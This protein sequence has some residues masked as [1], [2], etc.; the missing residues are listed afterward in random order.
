MKRLLIASI[1]VTA[2]A[3]APRGARAPTPL[4][5]VDTA[6]YVVP[7]NTR[8]QWA[9]V[10]PRA[11]RAAG[12]TSGAP[13]YTVGHVM[14]SVGGTRTTSIGC[15][16]D[17]F[18]V[19]LRLG[20]VMP[21]LA[22]NASPSAEDRAAWDAFV[23]RLWERAHRREAIGARL[24]DSLRKELKTAR[25]MECPQLLTVT[26]EKLDEFP[27]RYSAAV[28]AAEAEQGSVAGPEVP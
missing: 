8:H 27:A 10:L 20:H 25:N 16:V 21:K 14:E 23:A 2:C 12:I 15:Q 26:R 19:Q 4:T 28:M 3:G 11:A 13:S 5:S 18:V 7:G 1:C 9:A 22:E 17:R 6:Y 24:A